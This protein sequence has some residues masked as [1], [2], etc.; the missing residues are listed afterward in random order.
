MKFLI[1]SF[2]IYINGEYAVDH[3]YEMPQTLA[4]VFQIIGVVQVEY[5]KICQEWYISATSLFWFD[6]DWF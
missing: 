3:L 1:F 5:I 4:K 2:Q 6:I